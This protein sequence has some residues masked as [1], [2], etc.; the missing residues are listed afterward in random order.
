MAFVGKGQQVSVLG[1]L[2]AGAGEEVL[3]SSTPAASAGM[4]PLLSLHMLDD[5]TYAVVCP[6]QRETPYRSPAGG[7]LGTRPQGAAPYQGD[8]ACCGAGSQPNSPRR[9]NGRGSP[10]RCIYDDRVSTII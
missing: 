1:T 4:L 5:R 7:N 10:T 6:C 3:P 8:V 9:G 2:A